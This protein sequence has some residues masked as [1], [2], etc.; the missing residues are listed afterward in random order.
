MA[1]T[2][3]THENGNCANRVLVAVNHFKP[4]SPDWLLNKYK[5]LR[6]PNEK[7]DSEY[8]PLHD[9]IMDAISS[10]LHEYAPEAFG[11]AWTSSMF[12]E[13]LTK[14]IMRIMEQQINRGF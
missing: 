1:E 14:E 6:E 5:G 7:R 3:N 10:N 8:S 12:P 9:S 4:I 11:A 2:L 13:R